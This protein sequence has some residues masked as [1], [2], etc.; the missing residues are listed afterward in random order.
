MTADGVAPAAG[1]GFGAGR[2]V[3]WMGSA[4]LRIFFLFASVGHL[5]ST[6]LGVWIGLQPR[7]NRRAAV[8]L[9]LAGTAIPITLVAL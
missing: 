9:L 4:G 8:G 3:R 5:L 7:R 6:C 2:S 1:R